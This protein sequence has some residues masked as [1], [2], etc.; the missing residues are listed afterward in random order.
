MRL[1]REFGVD[2]AQGYHVGR[3]QPAAD[4]LPAARIIPFKPRESHAA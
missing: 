3:L 2:Y 1:L 4:I